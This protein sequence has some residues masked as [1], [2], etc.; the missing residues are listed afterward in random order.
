MSA[1]PADASQSSAAR[2]TTGRGTLTSGPPLP[3]RRVDQLLDLAALRGLLLTTGMGQ[4][5]GSQPGH[6]QRRPDDADRQ[7]NVVIG[8]HAPHPA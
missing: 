7:Q 2:I 8:R 1:S 6:G 3:Q 5:P 4:H